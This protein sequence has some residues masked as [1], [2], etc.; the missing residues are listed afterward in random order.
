MLST[1]RKAGNV[2]EFLEDL[3]DYCQF[4]K[5]E[6]RIMGLYV[7]DLF[8]IILQKVTFTENC[9]GDKMPV[10]YIIAAFDWKFSIAIDREFCSNYVKKKGM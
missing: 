4:L 8:F 6:R 7:A 10:S 5:M 3:E 2:R 1:I 9:I